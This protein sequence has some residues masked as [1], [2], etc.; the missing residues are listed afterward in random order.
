MWLRRELTKIEH[1]GSESVVLVEIGDPVQALGGEPG[2]V[3]VR[4]EGAGARIDGDRRIYGEDSMQALLL[5]IG[6]ARTLLE[7]DEAF[8]G[9]RLFWI[10]QEGGLGLELPS[11]PVVE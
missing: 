6:F 2:S 8:A 3:R 5:G 11:P 7:S 4:I 9:R 1:D 10:E